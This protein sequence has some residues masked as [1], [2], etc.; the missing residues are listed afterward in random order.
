MKSMFR[1]S[2]QFCLCVVMYIVA[3]GHCSVGHASRLLKRVVDC[4]VNAV[5]GRGDV[6]V[7]TNYGGNG[8]VVQGTKA[9]IRVECALAIQR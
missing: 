9:W 2:V 6:R 8:K 5:T 7:A 3:N 1:R 4:F